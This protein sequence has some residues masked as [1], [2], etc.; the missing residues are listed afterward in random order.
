[1]EDF[2]TTEA[3]RVFRIQAEL[4]DGIE[5]LKGLG[6]AVAVFGSARL[7]EQTPYYRQAL[8]LGGR[9]GD[10]G[11]AVITGGGPGIM[12]A[13]NRGCFETRGT[14][15]GLNIQL[16]NEQAANQYHDTRMAFRYFFIRKLMFIKSCDAV[17][18]FPGGFGTLDEL[19]ESLTLVQTGRRLSL[20]VILIGVDYWSGLLAW[21]RERVLATG[22]IGAGDFGLFHVTD[23]LDRVMEII[24]EHFRRNGLEEAGD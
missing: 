22:C 1:M 6:P 8:E 13:A 4:I 16:P 11:I 20:P 14:S 21:L 23:D 9:L 24:Q 10:A 3:W 12:E 5:T 7:G 2:K 18:V 15:V 17:V 19:F